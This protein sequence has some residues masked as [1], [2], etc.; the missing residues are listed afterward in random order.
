MTF[1]QRQAHNA[2][3]FGDGYST[4]GPCWQQHNTAAELD[5]YWRIQ[6]AV[7]E[8]RKRWPENL[9]THKV[10]TGETI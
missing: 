1:E 10:G 2:L 8:Y 6:T 9:S 4:T 7:D 3:T 5:N